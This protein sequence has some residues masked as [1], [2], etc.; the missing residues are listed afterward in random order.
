MEYPCKNGFSTFFKVFDQTFFK[1]FVGSKG[2]ALSRSPQRAELP[3]GVGESEVE[4]Q[5]PSA[6]GEIP[7]FKM[8]F[9]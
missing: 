1:K 7:F 4:P 2:K 6:D 9:D 3:C 8:K 5:A